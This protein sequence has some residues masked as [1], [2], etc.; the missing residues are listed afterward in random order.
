MLSIAIP[1]HLQTIDRKTLQNIITVKLCGG[2]KT[3]YRLSEQKSHKHKM[4][5]VT[6]K[7]KHINALYQYQVFESFRPLQRPQ[8]T[9]H[10]V[11][12]TMKNS[13]C[14]SRRGHRIVPYG[15]IQCVIK[16]QKRHLLFHLRTE[17][18]GVSVSKTQQQRA[19][20]LANQDDL[21]EIW[22]NSESLHLDNSG[23][24]VTF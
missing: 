10:A 11:T 4:L 12:K 6:W 18:L 21:S 1:L 7:I 2:P 24:L 3:I 16:L 20:I 5:K 14:K 8:G 17:N 22:I 23:N 19:K 9:K 13:R 15:A